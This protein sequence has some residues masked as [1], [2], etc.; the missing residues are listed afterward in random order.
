MPR[1]VDPAKIAHGA[2]LYASGKTFK[3]AAAEV[4]MDP[5]SLRLILRRA[6]V[7]ARP[8]STQPAW[9]R[10]P[11]PKD[12]A[13]RYLEGQSEKG[14]GAEYGVSRAVIKRWLGELGVERRGPSEA[15]GV[16]LAQTTAEYRAAKADAA[17]AAT[18][19]VQMSEEHAAKIALGRERSGYGG[20]TSPGA[21]RLSEMLTEAGIE[22]IREKAVGR[23]NLDFALSAHPVAVE[24]LGGNWHSSKSIHAVRTPRILNAGWNILFVWDTTKYR[25][26]PR[27]T[28]YLIAW[29]ERLRVNPPQVCEYRVIRGDGQLAAVGKADDDEFP[30]VPPS[31]RGFKPRASHYRPRQDAVVV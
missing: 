7:V 9:N 17:H 11:V 24:V 5:E 2:H 29:A 20:R 23:Y 13:R 3:E 10:K 21:D 22:H 12:V 28:D 8:R 4:C 16:F 1:K 27:A 31:V 14:L 15:A 25:L 6:G 19:G 30:L 26:C 18:R